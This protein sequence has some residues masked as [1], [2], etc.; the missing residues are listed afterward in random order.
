MGFCSNFCSNFFG[1]KTCVLVVV[2]RR[3]S[4]VVRRSSNLL[5]E[6]VSLPFVS[7]V[8][9][10]SRIKMKINS[11][12]DNYCSQSVCAGVPAHYLFIIFALRACE[13]HHNLS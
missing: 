10:Q 7:S 4:F 12:F 6:K 1:T 2:V 13:H 3:S 9:H 5:V 11:K 8:C